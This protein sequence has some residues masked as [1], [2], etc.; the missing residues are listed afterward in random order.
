[1]VHLTKQEQWVLCLVLG[2][3]LVGWAV[4]TYRAA[5]PPA[6]PPAALTD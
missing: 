4:Q 2:L 3:V 1:M 6:Q 5:H